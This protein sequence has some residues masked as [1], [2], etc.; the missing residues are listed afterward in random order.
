MSTFFPFVVIPEDETAESFRK[1]KP[2]LYKTCIAAAH[3][4]NTTMQRQMS[5]DLLKSIAERVL[6][7]SEKSLDLLQGILVFAAWYEPAF[8]EKGNYAF[9]FFLSHGQI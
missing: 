8:L 1:R 5:H 6:V 3:H 7:N 9:R 4:R 2:L